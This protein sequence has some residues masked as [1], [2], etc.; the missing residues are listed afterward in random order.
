[1]RW[2]NK[3]KEDNSEDLDNSDFL[4]LKKDM[5]NESRRH[6]ICDA[7]ISGRNKNER[8][9]FVQ[10]LGYDITWQELV[11]ATAKY[12]ITSTFLRQAIEMEVSELAEIVWK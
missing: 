7:I 6:R 9:E 10:N 11:N 12:A 4:R 1:M 5:Q 3:K 8:L 2:F